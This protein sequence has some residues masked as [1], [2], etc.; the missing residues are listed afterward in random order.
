MTTP[1]GDVLSGDDTLGTIFDHVNVPRLLCCVTRV[2]KRYIVAEQRP[3]I[4]L[5]AS[6]M[7]RSC[8]LYV[9]AIDHGCPASWLM[10]HAA[11]TGNVAMLTFG[12]EIHPLALPDD[13]TCRAAS[14]AGHVAVLQWLQV[15]HD[16]LPDRSCV[17]WAVEEGRVA[18]LEW[19]FG[20]GYRFLLSNAMQ[21]ARH[22]HLHVLESA[23]RA[24]FRSSV[25][26]P[27]VMNAATF[28]AHMH[29]VQ[30]LY[31]GQ[32]GWDTST[33]A[34]AARTGNLE[35]LQWFRQRDAPWDFFTMVSAVESGKM[36]LLEWVC[37][38]NCPGNSYVSRVAV[39]MGRLDMLRFVWEYGCAIDLAECL[40]VAER[41]GHTRIY[42]Y[43][44]GL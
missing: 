27:L 25:M 4:P 41:L 35:L 43:L 16:V 14:K 33:C 13:D 30:W 36:P 10:N 2:W 22:G 24:G 40:G 1:C 21:A 29:V 8:S 20:G 5:A 31:D 7:L 42:D 6:Y 17:S 32:C 3:L 37:A 44:R 26:S 28:H 19:M 9:W 15:E 18:A 34:A 11:G 38:Q 12:Q 39:E 23:L